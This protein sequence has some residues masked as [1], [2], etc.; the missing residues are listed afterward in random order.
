MER[1]ASLLVRDEGLDVKSL[2]VLDRATTVGGGD[3]PRSAPSQETGRMLTHRAE[4][5]DR[6]ARSFE[7]DLGFG[8]RHFG[9]DGDAEARCPDL[10]EGNSAEHPGQPDGAVDLVLHPR[11]ARFARSHI[12]PGN[13]LGEP[14][15]HSRE[16]AHEPFLVRR[17]AVRVG[18]DAGL[19]AAMRQTRRRILEGHGAR[20]T[21]DLVDRHIRGHAHTADGGSAGDV[22]DDD[23]GI[24]ANARLAEQQHL[25]RSEVVP[26]NACHDVHIVLP[27]PRS[28]LQQ[29]SCP[30]HKDA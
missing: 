1:E 16:G 24:E 12:R 9:G 11:H 26:D 29:V 13:V 10:V 18:D 19:A 14:A 17:R 3:Q 21:E 8:G 22:V 27:C 23:D 2:R 5:L 28:C 25:R 7:V 15:N 20:E 4:A 6:H 30:R